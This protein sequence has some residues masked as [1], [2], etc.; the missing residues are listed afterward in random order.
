MYWFQDTKWR[1]LIRFHGRLSHSSQVLLLPHLQVLVEYAQSGGGWSHHWKLQR[2]KGHIPESDKI[3]SHNEIDNTGK[4]K[5]FFRYWT[6]TIKFP[7]FLSLEET[8]LI[9]TTLQPP[10]Y[11]QV[12][13]IDLQ[14]FFSCVSSPLLQLSCG[15]QRSASSLRPPQLPYLKG[16]G[17]KLRNLPSAVSILITVC[18]NCYCTRT[19]GFL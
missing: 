8:K 19:N 15:S 7:P 14:S 10:H 12:Q 16:R 4:P 5:L 13:L 2:A 11:S 3:K 6:M 9:G 18:F 1:Y 17:L